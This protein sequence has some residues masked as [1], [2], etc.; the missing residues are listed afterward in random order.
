M[1]RIGWI[2][3]GA[4]GKPM[5]Q[6]LLRSGVDITVWNRTAA[7]ME[8]LVNLGAK[9]AKSPIELSE[10]SDTILLMLSDDAAVNEVLF[11]EQGLVLS[12]PG[13]VD[14]SKPKDDRK[15]KKTII[16]CSTVSPAASKS[17]LKR[18][19]PFGFEYLEA[20]VTGSIIQAEEG[21]LNFLIGGKAP[22]VEQNVP[23]FKAMGKNVFY[24]GE[25]GSASTAKLA[26]NTIVALNLLSL[27]EGLALV[28]KAQIDPGLFL[29]ILQQGGARS[30]VLE[31]KAAKLLEED[32]STQFSVGLMNKDLALSRQ[33]AAELK[34]PA[35]MLAQAK[36]LFVM[37]MNRGYQDE[38]VSAM[39]KLYSHF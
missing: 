15:R 2:G 11:G 23:L 8:D 1:E 19:S 24:L 5:A 14:G 38:D 37:G 35:L 39:V 6:N 25:I 16:N 22:L 21:K 31:A 4:M 30:A 27:I 36:E 32:F 3:L 12:A 34:V 17:I 9:P 33:L 7:A 20:P 18:L 26:S 29:H 10:Q 28:K 13:R